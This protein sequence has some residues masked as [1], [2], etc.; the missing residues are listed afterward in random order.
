MDYNIYQAA[1]YAEHK[2][3]LNYHTVLGGRRL[4][5]IDKGSRESET[6]VLMHGIPTSSWLYRKMIPALAERYRVIVPDMI[7]FGGSEKPDVWT[8]YTLDVQAR[9]TVELLDHLGIEKWT[10]VSHDLGGPWTFELIPMSKGRIK[11]Y[12][13]LNS[14]AYR[15]G[16]N[17]PPEVRLM[18]KGTGGLF[19]FMLT[20][21]LFG[22][23]FSKNAMAGFVHKKELFTQ[24][25]S[26]GYFLPLMEKN[27][28]KAWRNFVQNIER[29]FTYLPRYAENLRS[30]GDANVPAMLAWGTRDTVLD[31]DKLPVQYACDLKIPPEDMHFFDDAH[32][33]LQ[34]DVPDELCQI[35]IA[36][37]EDHK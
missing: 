22:R 23:A 21:R 33:F 35:L 1:T 27:G 10:H 15:Y 29:L 25:V 26:D 34:E 7:G 37:M 2:S 5:Y 36:F 17:P 30:L 19:T 4:A 18:G 14:P 13:Q 3:H 31:Y 20:N 11:R 24:I 9:R 8:E 12:V 16:W 28:T 6:I 32:H